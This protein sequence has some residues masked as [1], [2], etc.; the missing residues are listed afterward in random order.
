MAFTTPSIEFLQQGGKRRVLISFSG[1]ALAPA[2]EL[3]I[4]DERLEG[5]CWKVLRHQ[6]DLTAG[7]GTAVNPVMGW[8]SNP[9]GS[10]KVAFQARQT[11][12]EVDEQPQ[13]PPIV[14]MPDGGSWYYRA[15]PN[16]A[17][18]DH[19]VAASILLEEL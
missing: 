11:A 9:A 15:V 16:N 17:A 12:Q 14:P 2:T 8:Q 4:Q 6:A 5:R 1:T 19:A 3:Q 13:T 18:A 7:T 10:A